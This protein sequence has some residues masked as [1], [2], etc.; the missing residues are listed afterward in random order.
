VSRKKNE[1]AFIIVII[2]IIIIIIII[3]LV[4]TFVWGTYSYI[5]E[6]N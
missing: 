6:V 2:I 3:T 5:P 1:M 4:I